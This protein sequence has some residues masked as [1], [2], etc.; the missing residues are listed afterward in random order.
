MTFF[1]KIIY[2]V[3]GDVHS[4]EKTNPS[5]EQ[6]AAPFLVVLLPK[7]VWEAVRLMCGQGVSQQSPESMT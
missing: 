4:G 7:E 3:H 1:Y 5:R 6:S 2:Q